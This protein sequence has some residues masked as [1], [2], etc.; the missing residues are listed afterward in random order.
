MLQIPREDFIAHSRY[1]VKVKSLCLIKHH[2]TETSGGREFS[3]YHRVE[4]G[5]GAHR[6]SYTMSTRGTFPGDKAAG[7]WSWPLTSI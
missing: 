7:S 6:A 3:F 1:K 5:S 2:A 4:N